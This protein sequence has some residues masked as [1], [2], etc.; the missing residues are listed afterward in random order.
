LRV[1][2][3]DVE[4]TGMHLA[5]RMQDE[6][7]D[8][9]L[10]NHQKHSREIGKNLIPLTESLHQAFAWCKEKPSIALFTSSGMGKRDAK[11]PV[12]ADEFRKA[13]I[14]TI[15]GGSFCDRLEHDRIFG[16]D[17]AKAAGARIPPTKTFSTI[18][19][20]IAFAKTVGDEAWYFK[21]D[22][23]LESDATYGG[24]DA[25]DLSR[26]LESIRSEFGDSIPNMLQQKIPGVALSTACWWNGKTFLASLK[27]EALGPLFL[28]HE[29]PV[30]LYDIN[31]IVA[32]ENGPWGPAGEAYFLEWTPRLGWDSEPT[33]L[34]LLT[35]PMV[36][37]F[38][39]L[40]NGTLAEAPFSTAEFAYSVR[41]SVQPYPFEHYADNKKSAYG[42]P[43]NGADGLWEGHFI[44]YSVGL[45]DQGQLYVADRWG[46]VGLSLATG[47]KLSVMHKA[48]MDYALEELQIPSL[49][50]RTD[51]AKCV[52]K[53]A[54]ELK[55]LGYE[56]PAGIFV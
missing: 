13:G 1:L 33:S 23:Y 25:E 7:A 26:Y 31:V 49:Q 47:T 4:A 50:A 30:G 39:K 18:S 43:I 24:K 6:G 17:I 45:S 32:K 38:E 46:L 29:A 15:A 40:T 10:Y 35:S 42:T 3:V 27:W 28:K 34:R 37:F 9:L 44:P 20:A 16:E 55:G 48:V 53:D 22:K 12:G 5:A 14:P 19:Q 2:I 21:S 52:I 54:K 11:T 51:G 8:V 36:E 56:V 41:L